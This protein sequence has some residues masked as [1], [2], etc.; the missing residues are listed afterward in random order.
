MNQFNKFAPA[1]GLLLISFAA[2]SAHSQQIPTFADTQFLCGGSPERIIACDVNVDGFDDIITL[3]SITG[4][5]VVLYGTNHNGFNNTATFS[6]GLFPQNFTVGDLNG[7]GTPDLI[8][9][10]GI[11]SLSVALNNGAGAFAITSGYAVSATV[12]AACGDFN[13]DGKLDVVASRAPLFVGEVF[14]M[15]GNGDGTLQLGNTVSVGQNPRSIAATDVN[16]DGKLDAVTANFAAGSISRLHGTGTG[17]FS[18]ALTTGVGTNP[19]AIILIDSNLDGFRDV[20]V[21][22]SITGNG[23]LT[24]AN[25]GAAGFSGVTTFPLNA[26]LPSGIAAADLNRDG[27]PEFITSNADSDTMT[28]LLATNGGQTYAFASAARTGAGPREIVAADFNRD[29]NTDLAT[30]NYF[31]FTT[32]ILTNQRGVPANVSLFGHGTGGCQGEIGINAFAAPKVG[33]HLAA[34]YTTNVPPKTSGMLLIGD[35][36][37]FNGIYNP[38]LDVW[39]HV[40][41]ASTHVVQ[42]PFVTSVTGEGIATIVGTVPPELAGFV[43]FAQAVIP[44]PQNGIC[45]PSSTGWSSSRGLYFTI[46]P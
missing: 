33:D 42:F 35:A 21:V 23:T 14:I 32:S 36:G 26:S 19:D 16:N 41:P 44:W 7:D 5:A 39:M 38:T 3:S 11:S 17:N 22:N 30:V 13:N 40:S 31:S 8:I 1:A 12:D 37:D 9:T 28:I 25:G 6:M 24:R 20:F 18:P 4:N 15:L 2:R 27:F 29:G 10:S 45:D 46:Q 34:V 43:F